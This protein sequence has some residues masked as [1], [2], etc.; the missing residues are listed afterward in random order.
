MFS[1]YKSKKEIHAVIHAHHFQL[2]KQ[3]LNKVDTVPKEI[4][5]GTKEM[6]LFISNLLNPK[7]KKCHGIFVTEGHQEGIFTYGISLQEA[8]TVLKNYAKKIG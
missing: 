4:S 3:L 5:Y 8:F 6:A 7:K 2:W 1:K